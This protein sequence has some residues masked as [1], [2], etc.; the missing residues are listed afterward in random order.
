MP[1]AAKACSRCGTPSTS[2]T[3][4][5]CTPT[6]ES[7]RHLRTA[8][9]RGNTRRWRNLAARTIRR[10]P[11]CAWPGGCHL[12][13]D[14]NNYLTVDHIVPRSVDPTRMYDAENLIVLCRRHNAVKG[15]RTLTDDGRLV[16][17]EDDQ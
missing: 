6:H 10:Q 12:P 5:T 17:Q 16:R 3:C 13:I 9:E 1:R 15:T 11:W 2:S 4:P 14:S 7:G 8:K